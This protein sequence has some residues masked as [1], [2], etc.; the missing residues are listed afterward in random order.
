MLKEERK[1]LKSHNATT[2]Q[3]QERK[4]NA[5][6]VQNVGCHRK[7]F[8]VTADSLST[9]DIHLFLPKSFDAG[10][11]EGHCKKLQPSP[12]TDHAHILSLYYRNN[13]D[14]SEVPSKCCVP[15]SYK[16][17]NLLFYNAAKGEH[18]IKP[19]MLAQADECDCL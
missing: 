3:P 11:C 7:K 9:G 15:V 1:S 5:G 13:V 16:K 4:R 17:I 8:V 10:V 18:I 6:N 14:L 2:T 19:N 12:R